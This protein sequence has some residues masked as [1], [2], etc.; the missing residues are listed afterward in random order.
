[1]IAGTQI[2]AA[3]VLLGWSQLDLC[4]RSGVSRATLVAFERGTGNPIFVTVGKLV[5][6]LEDA[7]IE[8]IDENQISQAK[9][10]GVRLKS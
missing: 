9:G 8:L 6:A 1:M 3:R 5:S 2:R 7:G 4:R 10:L